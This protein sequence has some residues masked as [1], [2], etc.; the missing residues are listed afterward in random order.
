M[1]VGAS[2]ARDS[3]AAPPPPATAESAPAPHV[4]A[5]ELP[6]LHNV[7]QVAEGILSGSEPE[8]DEGLAS[9]ARLG[10]KTVVSVDGAIPRLDAAH[11]HGL[12]YVHLPIGYDGISEQAGRALARVAREAPG[13]IYIHCHHGKHRGS[14]AAAVTCVAAGKM[15]SRDALK[16]LEMAGT[17]TE[18]AG[19]W[20]D[21]EK[22]SAPATDAVLPE[23]VESAEVDLLT[24]AM[25]QVDRR[26]DELKLCR[27]AGWRTPPG[28][29]DVAPAQ[30]ALLVREGLHEALRTTPGDRY[31]DAFREMM[32][33]AE[34]LAAQVET[35]LRE[36][37][38]KAASAGMKALETSCKQCHVKFRN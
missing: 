19:L 23:L 25:A 10:I 29:P 24:A 12:R 3:G 15:S 36:S 18:Y 7:Y 20:R 2:P 4:L 38:P 32:S 31:D 21:V 28:Q 16:I 1:A 17:G 6:G 5:R 13:P 26:F 33:A 27:D 9:L 37:N 34:A 11:Q 14:A 30:S 22:Y 35:A 8:G